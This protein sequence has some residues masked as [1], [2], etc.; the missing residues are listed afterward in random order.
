M[1]RSILSR[2]R[3]HGTIRSPLNRIRTVAAA[4]TAEGTIDPRTVP[5]LMAGGIWIPS[6]GVT[7]LGGGNR[8]W[9]SQ[10]TQTNSFTDTNSPSKPVLTAASNG[11]AVWDVSQSG[12]GLQSCWA[13]MSPDTALRFLQKGTY[14]VWAK[15]ALT[16]SQLYLWSQAPE[17]YG[18]TLPTNNRFVLWYNPLDATLNGAKFSSNIS[19]LGSFADVGNTPNLP[20]RAKANFGNG[21]FDPRL[22]HFYVLRWDSSKTNYVGSGGEDLSHRWE[23]YIDG[24]WQE[25]DGWSA[26][27]QGT[28]L[29]IEA[30]D[31]RDPANGG[32]VQAFAPYYGLA[33]STAPLVLGAQN[34]AGV[35]QW[36]GLIGPT[37]IFNEESGAVSD[38]ILSGVM[39]FMRPV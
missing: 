18:G 16:A 32:P 5:Q 21:L 27:P 26:P 19:F 10:A 17:G 9:A 29:Y 14:A 37:Y 13:I 23:F 7:S 25:G 34:Y 30:K 38:S 31:Y 36:P 1:S 4:R 35:A 12:A 20:G 39:N 22:W 8:A 28:N 15:G 24:I 11:V 33:D 6:L 3:L 2:V